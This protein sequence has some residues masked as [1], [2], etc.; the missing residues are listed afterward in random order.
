M[1]KIIVIREEGVGRENAEP[2]VRSEGGSPRLTELRQDCDE[3][4]QG[5]I[6]YLGTNPDTNVSRFGSIDCRIQGR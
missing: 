1:E 2:R 3:Q 4:D 6:R 5:Q